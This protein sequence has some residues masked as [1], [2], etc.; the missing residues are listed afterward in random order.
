[1]STGYGIGRGLKDKASIFQTHNQNHLP[2]EYVDERGEKQHRNFSFV[3]QKLIEKPLLY[4]NR[5]FDIRAWVLFN[6]WDGTVYL[7]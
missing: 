3:V 2:R 4:L 7:W 6:S 5:K 1:M